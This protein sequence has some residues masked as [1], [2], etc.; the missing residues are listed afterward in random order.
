ME[1]QHIYVV[2]SE[3]A[4]A[5]ID[6]NTPCRYGAPVVLVVAFVDTPT[7]LAVGVSNW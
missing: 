2:K 4:L 5:K 1:E 6:S 7:A 3:D